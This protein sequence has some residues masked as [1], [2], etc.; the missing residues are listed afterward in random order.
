ML[1]SQNISPKTIP[2]WTRLI[3]RNGKKPILTIQHDL[4]QQV[5]HIAIQIAEQNMA[6]TD[7]WPEC[8]HREYFRHKTLL[9]ACEKL[10]VSDSRVHDIVAKIKDENSKFEMIIGN[11]VWFSIP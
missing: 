4:I 8:G 2:S 1:N 11:W 6:I 7:A 10:L 3:S 9:Q 5:C